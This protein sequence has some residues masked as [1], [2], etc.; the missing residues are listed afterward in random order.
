MARAINAINPRKP[1]AGF[2]VVNRFFTQANH[3]L[4]RI[5]L[6]LNKKILIF[7]MPSR[8]IEEFRGEVGAGL[9]TL[10]GGK[11]ASRG[12]ARIF[13]AEIV[14]ERSPGFLILHISAAD[15]GAGAHQIVVGFGQGVNGA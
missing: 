9:L 3:C 2:A 1:R 13:H 7:A 6:F 14:I 4:S 12:Q 11:V 15:V 8:L 5:F 10:F